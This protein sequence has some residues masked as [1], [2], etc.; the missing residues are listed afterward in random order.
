VILLD[1]ASNK[2]TNKKQNKYQL[3]EAR[4]EALLLALKKYELAF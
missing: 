3:L 2:Q 4:V 1:L